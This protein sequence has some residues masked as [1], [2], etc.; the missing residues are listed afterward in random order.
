MQYALPGEACPERDR[1]A[2]SQKIVMQIYINSYQNA[3]LISI[4]LEHIL[5]TYNKIYLLFLYKTN[6][7][8]SL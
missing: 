8:P 4:K 2:I 5:S 3:Q 1:R 6:P 7:K